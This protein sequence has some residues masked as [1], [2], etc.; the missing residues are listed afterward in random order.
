MNSTIKPNIDIVQTK[1]YLNWNVPE[2]GFGELYIFYD[3][4][5][6]VL[7]CDAETMSKD[8]VRGLL[9]EAVDGIMAKAIFDGTPEYKAYYEKIAK[10]REEEKSQVAIE[11]PGNGV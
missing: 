8:F 9:N 4:D 6:E 2:I 11:F 1:L 3:Q 5:E 7:V 10:E